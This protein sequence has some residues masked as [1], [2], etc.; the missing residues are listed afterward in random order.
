MT[1]STLWWS[2]FF[3]NLSAGIF[4]SLLVILLVDRALEKERE[5]DKR[6]KFALNR[7]RPLIYR[8]LQTLCSI[9]K[10]VT[11][12]K[13]DLFPASIGDIFAENFPKLMLSLDLTKKET[14]TSQDWFIYLSSETKDLTRNLEKIIEA[15]QDSLNI[16]LLGILESFSNSPL[17]GLLSILPAIRQKNLTLNLENQKAIANPF[18]L[19]MGFHLLVKNHILL[20]LNLIENMNSRIQNKICLEEI[21][22]F[23][24]D[25]TPKWGTSRL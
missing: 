18:T 1:A 3:L 2:Q 9:F 4:G 21:S 11:S 17:L 25:Y 24:N 8:H 5:R 20:L 22:V 23:R 12:K 19:T 15:Y 6:E 14:P 10:A 16:E 13:P 7:L